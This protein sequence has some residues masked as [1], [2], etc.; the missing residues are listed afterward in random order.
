MF[1]YLCHIHPGDT[2]PRTSGAV[3][4]HIHFPR[5]VCSSSS[6]MI[7]CLTCAFEILRRFH[8]LCVVMSLDAEHHLEPAVRIISDRN[9]NSF[10]LEDGQKKFKTRKIK[11]SNKCIVHVVVLLLMLNVKIFSIWIFAFRGCFSC[12]VVGQKVGYLDCLA[13]VEYWSNQYDCL[14][15]VL[16]THLFTIRMLTSNKHSHL[17]VWCHLRSSMA[18]IGGVLCDSW[19]WE[20]FSLF[21]GL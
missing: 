4:K 14:C 15:R 5:F 2:V 21:C 9:E 19:L 1:F 8:Y 17:C 6:C 20:V 3:L 13:E 18:N 10:Y 11:L 7:C 12:Q 16:V